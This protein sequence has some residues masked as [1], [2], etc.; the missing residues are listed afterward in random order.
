[1][2]E[3]IQWVTQILAFTAEKR[4]RWFW[5]GCVWPNGLCQS[6][7]GHKPRLYRINTDLGRLKF[8]VVFRCA[9]NISESHWLIASCFESKYLILKQE[10][11][12][13]L[14]DYISELHTF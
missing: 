13:E 3:V 4:R 9:L 12:R 8:N 7:P 1:M 5:S 14:V 10:N 6:K 2:F 11:G